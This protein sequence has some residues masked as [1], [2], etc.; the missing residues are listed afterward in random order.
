MSAPDLVLVNEGRDYRLDAR[1][2]RGRAYL[3]ALPAEIPRPV[4][5]EH[6]GWL[7]LCMALQR[8]GFHV[9]IIDRE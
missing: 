4:T 2:E 3:D 9:N 5:I 7:P 1:T 8:E 6:D